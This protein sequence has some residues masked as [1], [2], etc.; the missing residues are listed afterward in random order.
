[1]R[2]RLAEPS[3]L[4]RSSGHFWEASGSGRQPNWE[5]DKG[6]SPEEGPLKMD[7]ALK[8]EFSGELYPPWTTAS[9]ER[10]AYADVT[11]RGKLIKPSLTSRDRVG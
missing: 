10:V 3:L 1:M 6:P 4:L 7:K 9:K 2:Q 5:N 8:S 11:G